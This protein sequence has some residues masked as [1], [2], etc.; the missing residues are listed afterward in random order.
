MVLI[1]QSYRAQFRENESCNPLWL[2]LPWCIHAAIPPSN[3]QMVF[4]LFYWLQ[5]CLLSLWVK[6]PFEQMSEWFWSQFLKKMCQ[7]D[8]SGQTLYNNH[9]MRKFY[10]NSFSYK[11]SSADYRCWSYQSKCFSSYPTHVPEVLLQP[12]VRTQW[13]SFQVLSYCQVHA[14]LSLSMRDMISGFCTD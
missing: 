6:S 3:P 10:W 11:I 4:R 5:W 9:C 13:H 7:S 14:I 8:H 1:L 2:L 12:S